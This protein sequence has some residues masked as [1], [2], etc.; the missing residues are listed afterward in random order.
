M[1][2]QLSLI[3]L[4]WAPVLAQF[5]CTICK[6][7]AGITKPDGMVTTR[8]GQTASCVALTQQVSNLAGEAC[9]NLQHIATEPCGCPGYEESVE[10]EA[11]A[12]DEESEDYE[13]STSNFGFAP[14]GTG[15][16]ESFLGAPS[17]SFG[18]KPVVSG[19]SESVPE[20]PFVCSICVSGEITNPGAIT[21]NSKGVPTNCQELNDNRESILESDCARIQSFAAA[22]CGCSGDAPVTID[23]MIE[24]N[25]ETFT[26]N[27]CGDGVIGN[28]NGIVINSRGVGKTC[29]EL[30]AIKANIPS[31]MCP[32]FQNNALEPCGC[33]FDGNAPD[34]TTQNE[35]PVAPFVPVTETQV[36]NQ[37]DESE[38]EV[39]SKCSICGGGEMVLPDGIV[40]RPDGRS[41][42]CDAL[43]ANPKEI[44]VEACANIQAMAKQPCGCII[45][46]NQ[47]SDVSIIDDIVP[48]ECSICGEGEVT[49]PDGIVT[50]PQ[51]QAARCSA[52]EANA[53]T[54]PEDSC[55]EIQQLSNGPCGCSNTGSVAGQG[56]GS[57]VDLDGSGVCHICG[58][59]AQKVGN[60]A[61]MVTTPSGMFTCYSLFSAGLAGAIGSEDCG[62][63]QAT[64]AEE[65]GCYVDGP[66]QAPSDIF[67]CPICEDGLYVTKPEGILNAES[68]M[69]CAQY[70]EEAD[71]GRINQDQCDVLQESSGPVCGC[72]PP[73]TFPTEAPTS[74]ECQL[75]GPRQEIRLP[76]AIAMLP[77]YQKMPCS[78][79][80]QRAE[81]GIIHSSQC[82]RFQP[83]AEEYCGCANKPY[84][85]GPE[86]TM[87]H[88]C[89]IC[90][91]GLKVTSPNSI[92]SI[93]NLGDRTCI[94][95]MTESAYG[96]FN[97]EQCSLLQPFVQG[98]CGCADRYGTDDTPP[99]LPSDKQGDCFQDLGKIQASERAVEDT[100]ITRLYVLCPGTTFDIGV[101]TEEGEI[102][103]GQ[104]FI[105]LRPNVIYQCGHDGSRMNDCIL[106]GGDFGLASYDGVYDGIN[107]IVSSVE[108]RGLTFESQ[109]LFS[110]LLKSAG[111]IT[112][113]GCAFKNNSNNVPVLMQWGKNEDS[114][115]ENR[116]LEE[117]EELKQ[118]VTFQDCVFRD[119]FVDDSLSFPGIIENTFNSELVIKNCLFQ[120]NVY[121]GNNNLADTGYAIRSFGHLTL[122]STCFIDNTFLNN[123]PVLVY[124]AQFEAYDNYV[125]TPQTDLACE[126]G[127]LF[128][129]QDDMAEIIPTCVTSDASVCAFSQGPTSSPTYSPDQER[130][131]D[132]ESNQSNSS[133]TVVGVTLL[134]ILLALCA[135]VFGL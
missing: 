99:E 115:S 102:D 124:G 89:N 1:R 74:F 131:I 123:G 105:A 40:T 100:S 91:S 53:K 24:D 126:L 30:D 17:D 106:K 61:N 6:G 108:I 14:V 71:R 70:V 21:L 26:C 117:P 27:I 82:E 42:R 37:N 9:E 134:P 50:T 76:D 116:R 133:A 73:P 3:A 28:P 43:D 63:V 47:G 62:A 64:A 55:T 31:A 29:A 7:G 33:Q 48:F 68:G 69:T 80:Q 110:I 59:A 94:E 15:A 39:L 12:E 85:E 107:E 25:T 132:A 4:A 44:T 66:T 56:S 36:E 10:I 78:T 125:E 113:T 35:T 20:A 57:W 93:P 97:E 88:D 127:A 92:V 83:I 120:D 72:S 51:G 52:L 19:A 87:T 104:P 23:T 112:F 109:N 34:I 65:C 96:K 75:C 114:L 60:A 54:V 18:F 38:I 111:D 103:D 84:E 22:P 81:S 67:R 90:G 77:N 8:E 95:L 58:G 98:P 2:L 49:I 13:V 128:S 119:N 121:G 41:A 16:S 129:S 11:L 122:E 32:T 86:S 5:T 135:S 46:Y 45:P 118:V 130:F 101:W 79:L